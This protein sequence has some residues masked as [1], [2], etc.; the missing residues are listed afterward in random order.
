MYLASQ[1][2]RYNVTGDPEAK[3]AAKKTFE[4]VLRLYKVIPPEFNGFMAKAIM[5]RGEL[6]SVK[7]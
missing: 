5:P 1:C 7:S 4:A 2:Y 6:P 3:Q